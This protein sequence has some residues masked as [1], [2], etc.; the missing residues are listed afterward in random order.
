MKDT[1]LSLSGGLDSCSALHIYKDKIAMAISFH[2]GSNHNDQEIKMAKLNC[3]RLDIPHKVIDLSNVFK[4][5]HSSLLGEGAIPEGHYEEASMK[6]TVVPF[7]NGIMLSV[8]TGIAED[9]NLKAVMIAS[10]SGDNAVYPDCRP[11][12]NAGMRAAMS[13][14]T[15][16]KIDLVTPFAEI[17]KPELAKMGITHGLIPEQTYS[18]YKGGE[19]PCGVCSTC[20]ERDWAL[21]LRKEP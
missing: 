10:H 17:S 5:M 3:E 6:S 19:V 8:L 1:L 21:G 20:R 18:C 7:R 16:N 4:G 12:F 13:Q 9:N 15:Y 14:G 11:S 2:Y